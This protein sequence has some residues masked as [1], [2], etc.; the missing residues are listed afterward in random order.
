MDFSQDKQWTLPEGQVKKAWINGQLVWQAEAQIPYV[1]DGLVAWWDGI[2][3]AGV[4][5]HDSASTT[6]ADLSGNGHNITNLHNVTIGEQSIALLANDETGCGNTPLFTNDAI[7]TI[8]VVM[9]MASANG[10]IIGF[11]PNATNRQ[12]HSNGN[13]WSQGSRSAGGLSVG[14]GRTFHAAFVYNGTTTA[15]AYEDGEEASMISGSSG[16]NSGYRVLGAFSTYYSRNAIFG[17]RLYSRALTA[18][19]IAHNYAI[20]KQR[21]NLP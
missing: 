14:S 18:A 2:W 11:N 8:E 7:S 10:G 19:E 1:T 9:T 15:K 3:N 6:W 4:G 13:L 16:F 21:F 17:I 20:D 12:L 5:V